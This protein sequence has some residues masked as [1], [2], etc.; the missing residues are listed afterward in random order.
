MATA[1]SIKAQTGYVP[2]KTLPSR[3]TDF[4][5][6]RELRSD[7][8]TRERRAQLLD[9]MAWLREYRPKAAADVPE[10]SAC[11]TGLKTV[12]AGLNYCRKPDCGG[13]A[14]PVPACNDGSG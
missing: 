7:G 2:G 4:E 5:I 9:H 13:Y 8:T 1:E 3:M 10:T 11:D 12:S 14:G 6:A